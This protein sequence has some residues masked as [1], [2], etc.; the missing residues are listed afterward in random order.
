MYRELEAEL[1]AAAEKL[2]QAEELA[3]KKQV[4]GQLEAESAVALARK[5]AESEAKN[6]A[7]RAARDAEDRIKVGMPSYMPM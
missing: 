5:E 1:K 7:A 4:A 6:E 3:L 2:H